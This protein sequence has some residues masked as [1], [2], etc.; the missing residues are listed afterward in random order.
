TVAALKEKLE[1]IARAELAR[2]RGRLGELTP[3]QER[4]VE[5]LLMSTVNK[6]SHPII[7]RLRRSHDT[8]EE[9]NLKAWRNTF[10]LEE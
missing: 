8:G 7:N 1:E 2:Q 4:A 6:I 3:E 9:E 5:A 10:G